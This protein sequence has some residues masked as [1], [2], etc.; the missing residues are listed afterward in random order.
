MAQWETGTPR[1][2]VKLCLCS[3]LCLYCIYVILFCFVLFY[4]ILFSPYFCPIYCCI[5][6]VHSHTHY[7]GSII[8]TIDHPAEKQL[9]M[10]RNF[11]PNPC[12]NNLCSLHV[13][14]KPFY[15]VC[16]HDF[17][18]SVL[19]EGHTKPENFKGKNTDRL[20]NTWCG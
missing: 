16:T 11:L 1:Y 12:H 7:S 15:L 10:C 5:F 9:H 20:A 3:V 2:Q 19:L 14:F 8:I 6:S 4:F 18:Q 17:H 13:V